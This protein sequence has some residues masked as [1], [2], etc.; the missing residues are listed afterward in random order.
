MDGFWVHFVETLYGAWL[1]GDSRGFRT[2]HHREHVEGDYKAPPPDGMHDEQRRRSRESLKQSPVVLAP[3]WRPVVGAAVRDRLQ[4]LGVFVLCLA[5]GGQHLH[6]LAKPP[7]G[8]DARLM[9]GL[10]KKHAAFE[11]K[12][13]G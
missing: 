1:Y 4:D 10:A 7:T 3:A 11:A 6:L 9:M 13:L 5:Q 8:T 12:G 2:R